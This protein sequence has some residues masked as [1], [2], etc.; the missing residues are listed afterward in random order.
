MDQ[1]GS[2]HSIINQN[3]LAVDKALTQ[4]ARDLARRINQRCIESRSKVDDLEHYSREVILRVT[5]TTSKMANLKN[6]KPVKQ[7]I[8]TQNVLK[9]E[10]MRVEENNTGLYSTAFL[11][12]YKSAI[13]KCGRTTESMQNLPIFP[14]TSHYDGP[15][16]LNGYTNGHSNKD[17]E[18]N[19]HVNGH[20]PTNSSDGFE[21]SSESDDEVPV[22]KN[23]VVQK[24]EVDLSSV[25]LRNSQTSDMEER[26]NQHLSQPSPM[27]RPDNTRFSS[28][29]HSSSDQHSD[30]TSKHSAENPLFPPPQT[31]PVSNGSDSKRLAG[32]LEPSDSST[33]A[34]PTPLP[35][36]VMRSAAMA[37]VIGEIREK[38][39]AKAKFFDSDSDSD[40]N[41]SWD[42]QPPPQRPPP[43]QIPDARAV[44]E[45]AEAKAA[46]TRAAEA[47]AADAKAAEA[48]AAE[49]KAAEARTAQA[50]AAL[51][52]R[53]SIVVEPEQ[54]QPRHTSNN[55]FDSDSDSD[56]EFVKPPLRSKM[57][58]E[59]VS[60]PIAKPVI[61]EVKKPAESNTP[62]SSAPPAAVDTKS[63]PAKKPIGKSLFSS[64]S[65]SDDEFLKAFAKPKSVAKTASTPAEKPVGKP[66]T[67][68]VSNSLD[69]SVKKPEPVAPKA[70][71]TP[72][73]KPTIPPAATANTTTIIP[74]K[75]EETKKPVTKS[76]FDDSDSDSDLFTSKSKPKTLINTKKESTPPTAVVEATLPEPEPDMEPSPSEQKESATSKK[77]PTSEKMASLIADLQIGFRLPGTPNIPAKTTPVTEEVAPEEEVTVGTILKGRCRGPSNRRPP[78]RLPK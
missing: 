15:S 16:Q 28:T 64:D 55:I 7:V 73:I 39:A 51:V 76:L 10:D 41:Q 40:N 65:D 1:N 62:K 74:R 44:R 30:R 21:R 58:P 69:R 46:E 12:S 2:L 29:S 77:G 72:V 45:A 6:F 11:E 54:V 9:P 49:A 70:V 27:D 36:V 67:A 68:A 33:T 32:S 24:I 37:S 35:K 31:M 71:E 19:G 78:T 4:K 48:R 34:E 13:M 38:T 52:A 50:R 56:T 20:P 23:P 66:L 59:R 3:S 61:E 26:G 25:R 63:A 22:V 75:V 42:Q 5:S 60:K 8:S 17:N 18:T 14:S 57:M 43:K 47:K 53:K